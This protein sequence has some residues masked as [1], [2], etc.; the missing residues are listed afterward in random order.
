MKKR[1]MKA[2]SVDQLFEIVKAVQQGQDPE[3]VLRKKQAESA[4]LADSPK[5]NPEINIL[6]G[7][8]EENRM[9]DRRTGKS[10]VKTADELCE[11][12][13]EASGDMEEIISEKPW[14][15]FSFLKREK[16]SGEEEDDFLDDDEEE[17][18][19][20]KKSLRKKTMRETADFDEESE[21]KSLKKRKAEVSVSEE[22]D[23]GWNDNDD[24]MNLLND[25]SQQSLD[26]SAIAGVIGGGIA[27]VSSLFAGAKKDDVKKDDA[28]K[29]SA[30]IKKPK[31][32]KSSKADSDEKKT[33]EHSTSEPAELE[34]EVS[35]QDI[36]ESAV[37][38]VSEQETAEFKNPESAEHELSEELTEEELLEKSE[39]AK[40]ID[41]I[42]DIPNAAEQESTSAEHAEGESE[43]EEKEELPDNGIDLEEDAIRAKSDKEREASIK[44]KIS[45]KL[46][47]EKEPIPE[48]LKEKPRKG[49]LREAEEKE[50]KVQLSNIPGMIRNFFFDLADGLRDKGIHR[51]ELIMIAIGLVLAV[52]I[53]VMVSNAIKDSAETKRKSENVTA[54]AGLTIT[55][56]KEP[57]QWCQSYPVSL[58]VRVKGETVSKVM[59]DGAY[60][61]PNE[62]GIITVR[63]RD[64]LLNASVETEGG[65][66]TA[67]IEIPKIDVQVP[68]VSAAREQNMITLTAADGRSGISKVWYAAVKETD[69]S[70]LPLYEEYTEPFPYE[71]GAMYYFYTEDLA[72]NKS[73]PVA[74]TMEEAEEIVLGSSEM[75]L[76]PGESKYLSVDGKPSGALMNNLTYESMN[77]LVVT[78]D[79]NGLITAVAEGTT[80]VKVK[81]DGL[82]EVLC[83]VEV[84][85]NRTVT[86]S[87]IGDCTLGS[88]YSFNTNINFQAFESVN[89]SAYFFQNVKAILEND[90]AT[91]AN[92]EGVFTDLTTR[93][94]KQYAFKGDPDYTQIL[95]DGSVEVVTLANNHS[96]DYG[97]QSQKDTK[98]YL[99]NAGI[100]YCIGDTIAMQEIKGVKTAFIGIYVLYDGMEREEQVRTT[101]AEARAQGAQL[102]IVAFHWGSEKATQP[103]QIQT[104]LAHIAVDA[105]ADLVV[106]HHPH[107]LQGIEKY[108]GKYIVYSLG[109][110]CFG[111]NTSPSDTDTIIFRQTF[112]I[113]DGA[114]L[115]DDQIEIVPCSISGTSGYNDYQPTPVTGTEADRIMERL[116]EYSAQF[117]QTYTAS[118]G[119]D[120]L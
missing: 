7:K 13:Q 116:N 21:T 34:A 82:S 62:E 79:G 77:P 23:D 17:D 61:E 92:L 108:N 59:V 46:S 88:D 60:Y 101:I 9:T 4:P 78:V 111:G 71:E 5:S 109:N 90:D 43:N 83:T 28:K 102:V 20:P 81:A 103:D 29:D 80:A 98:Q 24:F 38:S 25:E 53:V 100:D 87:T 105:G 1:K 41:R 107:V 27:M 37:K 55:V 91:F 19:I 35:G 6:P 93:E 8:S 69:Y 65:T 110:F 66:L 11:D 119:L 10:E 36:S 50:S 64:Y 54:D 75:C 33:L 58:K 112:T 2:D 52:L 85:R 97:E 63:A 117:E 49:G 48:Q 72:G 115:D 68:V 15:K 84:S 3:E 95:L 14:K 96:S 32:K 39:D 70:K 22:S 120:I 114:V 67:Q 30:K 106:G 74:T 113:S 16:W 45:G 40:T 94:N 118:T 76:F 26:V 42:L 12:Q 86:I 73:T 99:T 51:K 89:G 57:E 18:R 47:K 44:K 56:E 104:S 31:K